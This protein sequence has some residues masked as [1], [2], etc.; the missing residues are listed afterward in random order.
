MQMLQTRL[1][2]ISSWFYL[3]KLATNGAKVLGGHCLSVIVFG[4][5]FFPT[6][7][8]ALLQIATTNR[9]R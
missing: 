2:Q 5:G 1:W 7:V 9:R 6:P 4:F 3:S 8:I